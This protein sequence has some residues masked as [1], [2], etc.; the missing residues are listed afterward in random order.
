MN[1]AAASS[2]R[3]KLRNFSV[4][5]LLFAATLLWVLWQSSRVAVLWDLGY[6]L[7]TSHRIAA[8]QIPYRDFSL[9]HPPLTFLIQAAIERL[10]GRHYEG[11]IAYAAIAGG[12]ASVLTWRIILNIFGNQ[13]QARVS[14]LL[15]SLPLPVLGIYSVYSHPIYDSDAMLAVLAS[16]L[17]LQ[18]A[19]RPR[20]TILSRFSAGACCALPLFVKQ[21]IGLPFL[22]AVLSA[23]LLLFLSR[24]WKTQRGAE[25][26]ALAG[27][28]DAAQIAAGCILAFGA[29]LLL[30]QCICGLGNYWH[31]TVQFAAQRRLPAANTVLSLYSEPTLLWTLPL[32]AVG[33][34][35]LFSRYSRRIWAQAAGAALIAAPYLA[36]LLYLL[37]EHNA[38]DR[39]DRLLAFWPL[40][41]L[42]ATAIAICNLRRGITFAS[43]TPFLVLA[44]IHGT[45]LSQEV[46]GST[47]AI[48]PLLMILIA[49]SLA[50]L[51]KHAG[52]PR[53]VLAAI[54]GMTLLICGSLYAASLERLDY[55]Y[56]LIDEPLAKATLPALH[57][58]AAR[59][60]YL[61][62][63]EQLVRFADKEIPAGD[64][65]LLLPGEEPFFYA[66][67][68]APRF[69]VVLFDHTTDPYTPEQLLMEADQRGIRWV[70]VKT[71]LQSNED[72]LPERER[73][74]E[75]V[76]ERFQLAR[77][78][79]G[80]DVY[81]RR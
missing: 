24:S 18:H 77:K 78:L 56:N 69:P 6:L 16:I 39:A 44:A 81:R 46:W 26:S 10:F 2:M 15:L 59:G 23:L 13:P 60:T 7:N 20:A 70:V 14:A 66:T 80:Y 25:S 32:F 67:G 31:W 68:R 29:A 75:L 74:M 51:P 64:G 65:I 37:L 57:G 4:A 48:W 38:E 12:I 53:T 30:I 50:A 79:D 33:F 34:V 62:D 19:C 22:A 8:G 54:T 73:L 55:I 11:V 47:Y 45:F 58:M 27:G 63:F 71:R 1:D 41:L 61:P 42:T 43:L 28:M 49:Y 76:K 9:V 36:A 52:K 5:A 21:N 3:W 40:L 17:L 72:P 35:L